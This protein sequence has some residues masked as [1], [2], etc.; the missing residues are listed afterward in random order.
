MLFTFTMASAITG[1][2]HVQ[3]RRQRTLGPSCLGAKPPEPLGITFAPRMDPAHDPWV[4]VLVADWSRNSRLHHLGKKNVRI[5]MQRPLAAQDGKDAAQNGED[6]RAHGRP[7][8]RALQ[9]QPR[10]RRVPYRD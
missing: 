3:Y 6:A 1:E 7:L 8:L 4:R 2:D 9:R 10:L 5:W